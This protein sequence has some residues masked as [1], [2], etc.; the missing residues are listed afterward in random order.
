MNINFTLINEFFSFIIFFI[1]SFIFVFPKMI[2]IIN[3]NELIHFKNEIFINYNKT[4]E[5]NFIK[6]LIFIEFKIKEN[7]DNFIKNINNIIYNKKNIL[8]NIILLEK[9]FL[10]KK[11]KKIIGEINY[12]FIKNFSIELKKIFLKSFKKIYNEI[13]IYNNEFIII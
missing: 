11:I 3:L 13:I 4:L 9:N 6:K 12:N 10:M 8:I 5:N 7:I 2:N 1:F